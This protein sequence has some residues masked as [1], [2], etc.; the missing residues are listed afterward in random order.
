MGTKNSNK[1]SNTEADERKA[2]LISA[3][4]ATGRAKRVSSALD[5]PIKIIS[6]GSLIQKNP[7]GKIITIKTIVK[8]KSNKPGIK[9]GA[10]LCLK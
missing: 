10:V 2:L 7:N 1:K 6:G 9:K 8:A 4:V 3:K 5:L